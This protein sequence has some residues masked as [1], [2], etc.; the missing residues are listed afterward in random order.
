MA[1]QRWQFW[2]FGMLIGQAVWGLAYA[3]TLNNRQGLPE[4]VAAPVLFLGWAL[5]WGDGPGRI[6]LVE[7]ATFT[8]IFGLCFYGLLGAV[9]A[10]IFRRFR[11]P[12]IEVQARQ[13]RCNSDLRCKA[14]RHCHARNRACSRA[15]SA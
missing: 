13:F 10:E 7:T 2:I 8:V 6:K 15:A 14:L 1:T 9:V 12:R 11:R 3:A 5:I 4:F